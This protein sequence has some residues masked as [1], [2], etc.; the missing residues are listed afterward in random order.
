MLLV[1][2]MIAAAGNSGTYT[3]FT[4]TVSRAQHPGAIPCTGGDVESEFV[5][6]M[7]IGWRA[8]QIGIILQR[9]VSNMKFGTRR[10]HP[11][12]YSRIL[13]RVGRYLHGRASGCRH[14]RI[15]SYS[16]Q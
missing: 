7:V 4:R 12:Y 16:V 3:H 9:M 14:G 13:R 1:T 6:Q 8:S 2:S 11:F 10:R 15:G 5:F